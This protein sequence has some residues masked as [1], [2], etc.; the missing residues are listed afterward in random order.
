MQPIQVDLNCPRRLSKAKNNSLHDGLVALLFYQKHKKANVS[1]RQ[2]LI[3]P[4]KTSGSHCVRAKKKPPMRATILKFVHC[5]RNST[6]ALEPFLA[7]KFER[8]AG[9]CPAQPKNPPPFALFFR[10]FPRRDFF[11]AEKGVVFR[12]TRNKLR[13]YSQIISSL[14]GSFVRITKKVSGSVAEVFI[15]S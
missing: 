5:W 13:V 6:T 9:R 4:K 2:N 15:N 10:D 14:P 11:G 12:D 7:Q 3:P 8:W 1:R